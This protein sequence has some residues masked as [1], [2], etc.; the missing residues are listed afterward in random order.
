MV[1]DSG[2]IAMNSVED[3]KI[4]QANKYW[5]NCEFA[6]IPMIGCASVHTGEFFVFNPKTLKGAVSSIY[7]ATMKDDLKKDSIYISYFSCEK[8]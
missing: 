2:R 7:G 1:N 5:L 8:Q 3:G 6:G 4:L